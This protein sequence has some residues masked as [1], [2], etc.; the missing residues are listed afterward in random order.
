MGQL[1][2]KL[3]D[4]QEACVTRFFKGRN[5]ARDTLLEC[6]SVEE[7]SIKKFRNGLWSFVR[8]EEGPYGACG[9][10][11]MDDKLWIMATNRMFHSLDNAKEAIKLHNLWKNRPDEIK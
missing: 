9:G 10:I 11:S 8:K 1:S 6:V 3:N 2:S 7:G 4:I 5:G